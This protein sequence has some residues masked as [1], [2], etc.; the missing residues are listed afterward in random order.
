[1][2]RTSFTVLATPLSSESLFRCW[3]F[4]ILLF[5]VT[6]I[7]WRRSPYLLNLAF[8]PPTWWYILPCREQFT[9]SPVSSIIPIGRKLSTSFFLRLSQ[10]LFLTLSRAGCLRC[11]PHY[12]PFGELLG[13]HPTIVP[14][15]WSVHRLSF[16]TLMSRA[17]WVT[18]MLRWHDDRGFR[19]EVTIHL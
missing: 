18:R 14:S 19:F 15:P 8:S 5:S 16:V 12:S 6:E 10:L 7:S 11:P 3:I 2:I 4:L 1:M 17:T 13:Y 9:I